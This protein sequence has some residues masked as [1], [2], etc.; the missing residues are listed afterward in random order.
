LA[1]D[2]GLKVGDRLPLEDGVYPYNL[3]LT[4]RGIYDGPANRDR[5]MCVYHWEYLDEGLKRDAKGQ[6]AG[7]AGIIVIKCQNGDVMTSLSRK[8]DA[9]YLNSDTP[10][11]TQTEEAFGKMFAEMMGDLQ[12]MMRNIGLAVVFS[13]FCVSGN[14]MAMALRERTTEVAVLKAIGFSKGLVIFLV[15]AEAVLVSGLGGVLGAIGSKLLFDA[16]DISPYSGGFLP[17]FFISWST[18]LMGLAVSLFIGFASGFIPA[19]NAA[20]LSVVN[21]LRKVV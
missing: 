7:N 9:Q 21:G 8:I 1:E 19:I 16:V 12:G 20:R 5:R 3:D 11:R 14:A 2:R 6:G 17:F 18:A 13:L 4:I 15:L 10:T